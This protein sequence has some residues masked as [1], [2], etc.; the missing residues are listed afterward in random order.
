MLRRHSLPA[1]AGALERYNP[2]SPRPGSTA[3]RERSNVP[4]HLIAPSGGRRV[5]TGGRGGR[6]R[7]GQRRSHL[8][9][10]QRS[11]AVV[12]EKKRQAASSARISQGSQL[13]RID[14]EGLLDAY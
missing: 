7:F 8:R 10:A 14:P 2:I 3:K 11:H 9:A 4:S 12:L 1:R 5:G 6:Q 13:S